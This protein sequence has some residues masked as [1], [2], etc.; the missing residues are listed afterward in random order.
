[1]PNMF[2]TEVLRQTP[3]WLNFLF[4]G[5]MYIASHSY[6]IGNGATAYVESIIPPTTGKIIHLLTRGITVE[7]GG[8]ITIDLYEAPTVTDG[9]TPFIMSN[10]DRRSAKTPSWQLF[11]DPTGVSGGTHISTDIVST[12]GGPKATGALVSGTTELIFHPSYRYVLKMTNLG[13]LASTVIVSYLWY[14][15]GN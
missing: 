9:T 11:S 2:K 3:Y 7:G 8:P 13:S 4:A 14:E 1:M 15:S 10:L 6:T 12:G 5:Q